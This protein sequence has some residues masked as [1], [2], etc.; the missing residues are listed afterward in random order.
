MNV[1]TPLPPS[2]VTFIHREGAEK[3]ERKR[4]EERKKGREGEDRRR[5]GE[6]EKVTERHREHTKDLCEVY[7]IRQC[8]HVAILPEH[9]E[10]FVT[11][12]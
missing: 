2:S 10:L 3:G 5:E 12:S 4:E 7:S 11:K 9:A 1:H 6:R 8:S